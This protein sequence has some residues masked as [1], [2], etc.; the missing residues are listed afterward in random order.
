MAKRTL[1]RVYRS[2][3]LS[4]EEVAQDREIRRKVMA[5]FPPL[6]GSGQPL[7]SDFLKTAITQSPKSVY[8]LAKETGISRIVITRFLSGERD[9]R[10]ATADK[11]AHVLGLKLVDK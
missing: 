9:L 5:E 7:L 10:L 3:R 1:K 11:L 8:Q 6:V 4:P 2:R